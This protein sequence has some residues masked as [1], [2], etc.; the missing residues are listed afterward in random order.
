MSTAQTD[1]EGADAAPNVDPVSAPRRRARR[2]ARV[3]IGQGVLIALFALSGVIA[4]ST[5]FADDPFPAPATVLIAS[6]GALAS[7]LGI[8]AAIGGL[9][10]RVVRAG[11]WALPLFFVWHVAALGTWVPDAAFAVIAAVGVALASAPRPRRRPA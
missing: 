10:S 2:G 6:F 3:R 4:L 8:T 5:L 7:V 1:L 11:L 9:D